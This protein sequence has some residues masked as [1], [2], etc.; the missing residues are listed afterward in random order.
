MSCR[1]AA[2]GLAPG[3]ARYDVSPGRHRFQL[4][5]A[6]SAPVRLFGWVADRN[7]GVTYEALGINGAEASVMLRCGPGC[8]KVGGGYG[9]IE[10]KRSKK[11]RILAFQRTKDKNGVIRKHLVST[12][13]LNG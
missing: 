10:Y 5:T 1:T 6:G 13:G 9:P 8:R 4:R 7:A 11:G 3:A 2:M 12:R